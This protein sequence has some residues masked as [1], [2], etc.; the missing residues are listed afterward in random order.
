MFVVE[1]TAEGVRIHAPQ[2]S[3][4]S[5][6]PKLNAWLM[7]IGFGL[8]LPLITVIGLVTFISFSAASPE[9]NSAAHALGGIAFAIAILISSFSLVGPAW[10]HLAGVYLNERVIEV[11]SAAGFVRVA[12]RPLPPLLTPG[13]FALFWWAA[14]ADPSQDH[15]A[16]SRTACGP[17][18]LWTKVSS[19]M[20]RYILRESCSQFDSLPLIIDD[21]SHTG[22]STS[23]SPLDEGGP[24]SGARRPEVH[25]DL[26]HDLP[27]YDG[28]LPGAADATRGAQRLRAPRRA[29]R[30]LP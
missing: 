9:D 30:P 10:Y 23:P 27:R 29:D 25:E 22:C 11:D 20:Y 18:L 26:A 14:R 12:I 8:A 3:P 24:R 28:V 1:D 16:V 2:Y 17:M 7:A 15:K 19:F 6:T 4:P 13:P 21:I 5:E